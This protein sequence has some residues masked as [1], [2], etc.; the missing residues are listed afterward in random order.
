MLAP[1]SSLTSLDTLFWCQK[2]WCGWFLIAALGQ[3]LKA[4]DLLCISSARNLSHLETGRFSNKYIR[5][6]KGWLPQPVG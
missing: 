1:G 4:S 6:L 5:N 3:S 2:S